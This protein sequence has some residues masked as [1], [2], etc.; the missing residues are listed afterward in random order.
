SRYEDFYMAFKA[1]EWAARC[2]RHLIPAWPRLR[3]QIVG[4]VDDFA[5]D[6]A[7]NTEYYQLKN[8]GSLTWDGGDHPLVED[9]ARQYKLAVHLGEPSPTT[10]LVVSG[11]KV[12][13]EMV[14]TLPE[15]IKEHTSVILFPYWETPN[16]L[17]LENMQLQEFLRELAREEDAP[18]DVLEGVFGVLMLACMAYPDGASLDEILRYTRRC[19]PHLIRADVSAINEVRDDFL[20]VLAMVPGLVYRVE[21]GFFRW[22]G[23][24]TSGVFTVDITDPAFAAFQDAVVRQR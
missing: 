13:T 15:R 8:V 17:V 1:A 22:E 6:L 16:R 14:E 23:F 12:A 5:I 9:F 10:N 24:G 20:G 7:E 4:F 2:F 11:G 18:Y 21:R 3:G 19:H